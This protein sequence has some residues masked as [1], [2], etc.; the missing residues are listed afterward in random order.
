MEIN[1]KYNI[2]DKLWTWKPPC[3]EV[4]QVIIQEIDINISR[5][6][7]QNITYIVIDIDD[8]NHV[9]YYK[10]EKELFKDKH[11]AKLDRQVKQKPQIKW[12]NIE[13]ISFV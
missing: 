3:D 10:G 2:G 5:N 6:N 12:D 4:F 13:E 11:W 8:G 1:N 7:K 9:L